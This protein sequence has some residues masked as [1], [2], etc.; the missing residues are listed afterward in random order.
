MH[1][2]QN[3]KFEINFYSEK[4]FPQNT[5]LEINFYSEMHFPQSRPTKFEINLIPKFTFP[6][7]LSFPLD[8]VTFP[9]K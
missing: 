7:I 1:C 3:T 5:K 4:Y 6:K 8:W 2:P 9:L